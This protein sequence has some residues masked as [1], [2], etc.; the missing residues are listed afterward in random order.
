VPEDQ[1]RKSMLTACVARAMLHRNERPLRCPYIGG[2]S[3]RGTFVR[4][5]GRPRSGPFQRVFA[6]HATGIVERGSR[7][8]NRASGLEHQLDA[9]G[10]ER[11]TAFIEIASS[12]KLSADLAQRSALSSLWRR[13]TETLCQFHGLSKGLHELR[14][15]LPFGTLDTLLATLAL[16]PVRCECGRAHV[17]AW[18]P[19]VPSRAQRRRPRSGA[20]PS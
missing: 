7:Q 14:V 8:R 3:R 1:Q 15:V 9:V 10:I 4:Y 17:G 2:Q 11:P 6:R 18:P 19:N 16:S 5:W 20:W 13:P 12:R